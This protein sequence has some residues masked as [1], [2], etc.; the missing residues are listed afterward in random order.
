MHGSF[1]RND[2]TVTGCMRAG[3]EIWSIGEVV[4]FELCSSA[5]REKDT[6]TGFELLKIKEHQ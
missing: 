2:N 1:G 5:K 4:M 3:V 6:R